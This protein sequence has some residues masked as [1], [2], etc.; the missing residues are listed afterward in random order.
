MVEHDLLRENYFK[1]KEKSEFSQFD[2]N[3][4]FSNSFDFSMEKKIFFEI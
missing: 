4:F 3:F 2:K 1:T